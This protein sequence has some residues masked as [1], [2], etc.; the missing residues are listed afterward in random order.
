MKKLIILLVTF[1][2][3]VFCNTTAS[4][5]VTLSFDPYF[6][7]V[8]LGNQV[9]VDV[10]ISGLG[11][12]VA[13]SLGAFN[14]DIGYNPTILHFTNYA[15]DTY[16]GDSSLFW[17]ALDLSGGETILG[18]VNIAEYSYLLATE[19]DILQPSSFTL[20]TL[21]FATQSLDTSSLNISSSYVL[22]DASGDPLTADLQSGSINVVPEPAT[23]F[24]L[25]TGLAGIGFLRKKRMNRVSS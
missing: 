8:S 18:L 16:L 2:M 3:L 4:Q 25:G 20:A 15:L 21:T 11:D 12:G 23:L 22:G 19:L 7:V 1:L 14:I 10:V 9:D 5:A 6:Q 17:E 13:P 24:L